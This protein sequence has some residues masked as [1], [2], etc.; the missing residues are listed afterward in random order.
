MNYFSLIVFFLLSSVTYA[1]TCK[2][3]S[4]AQSILD[5]ALERDPTVARARGVSEQGEALEGVARQLPNPELNT[6]AVYGDNFGTR[7]GNTQVSLTHNFELG[8]KRA[9][10]IDKAV[11]DREFAKNEFQ[12][13]K[14]EI[15]I[16]TAK[17]LYRI[18]HLLNEIEIIDEALAT[19][20]KI[21]KQYRTRPRLNP[22]QQVTSSIFQLAE[23]DYRL[24][25]A[26]IEAELNDLER[27]LEIAVGTPLKIGDKMLP[28]A[29]KNWP[30]VNEDSSEQLSNAADWRMSESFLKSAQAEL[31]IAKGNSWPDLKIGPS[32]Q[33]E[34]EATNT[35]Q[36]Y[37]VSLTMQLPAYHLNS[38]GRSYAYQNLAIAEKVFNSKKFEIVRE[39]KALVV[40]YQKA[41]KSLEEAA[42]NVE[43]D[44][45]HKN[46]ESLFHRGIVASAL[47]IE[48]HRQL[49]DFTRSK[50][51]QELDALEAYWKINAFD[52][53]LLETKL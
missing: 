48:A 11:A 28:T 9:G 2:D 25:K 35:F 52:G 8:G 42:S 38:A 31:S 37:G 53:K 20:S 43:L 26:Q 47:V 18:R 46:I 45:K 23:G 32:I 22:E 51:D 19:F 1:E 29:K 21:H 13:T 44:K 30:K 50:N 6:M 39:R 17:T 15:F 3:L 12:K 16:S 33:F 24:K 41:L 10:R 14:E 49:I 7:V 5:C 27:H 36:L 34:T 40:R 4:S